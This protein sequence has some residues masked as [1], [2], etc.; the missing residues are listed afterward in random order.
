MYKRTWGSL[1]VLPLA[2]L[3][4]AGLAAGAATPVVAQSSGTW[5]KT[6]SLTTPRE[7]QTAILLQNAK[8]LV[9]GGNST[10]PGAELYDP[11]TGKWAATGSPSIAGGTATVLQNGQVLVAG[12]EEGGTAISSAEL[13]NPVT[14]T[15]AATGSM[16]TARVFNTA[17]LLP[18]GQVLV[19]GGSG[20]CVL[21]SCPIFASAEL[22]NPAT[23]TWATTGSMHTAREL[24]TATLLPNDLVLVAG[25]EWTGGCPD[26]RCVR[27][28]RDCRI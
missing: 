15:W 6:A 12:G 3:L 10:G 14:G 16:H 21:G 19:A 13:Y 9:L 7:G 28:C 2:G 27:Q 1:G 24:H 23:G 26:R 25:G 4:A 18:N 8:V 11:A 17:T 5:A 20:D 22:Y